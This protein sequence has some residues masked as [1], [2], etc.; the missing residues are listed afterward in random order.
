MV[1]YL[2]L[3]NQKLSANWGYSS[4]VERSLCIPIAKLREVKGSIPFDSIFFSTTT[5]TPEDGD[6]HIL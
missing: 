5:Y 3:C 4:V 2:T 6:F 1:V